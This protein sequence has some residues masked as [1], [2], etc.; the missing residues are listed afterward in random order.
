MSLRIRPARPA[1]ADAVGRIW[2]SAWR[3]GHLGHVPEE[4]VAVRTPESFLARA[5]DRVADTVVAVVEAG[6]TAQV[7]GF[8]MLAGDEVEQIFVDAAHRGTDVA[9]ALLTKAERLLAA[10][11]HDEAWLAVATGNAR[12]RRFYERRGWTDAGDL[13]Y[14]AKVPGR[15]PIHVP[16]RRYVKRLGTPEPLR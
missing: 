8:V 4:L 1:D 16:T 5:A 13:D 14:A 11:G 7:A 6:G 10:A 3:D 2:A 9:T 15:P 12:A